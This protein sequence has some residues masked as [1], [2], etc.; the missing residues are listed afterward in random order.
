M[1]FNV[2]R[3]NDEDNEDNHRN[4]SKIDHLVTKIEKLQSSDRKKRVMYCVESARNLLFAGFER[5]TL[6]L[7]FFGEKNQ[8]IFSL[9]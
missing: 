4:L 9:P 3:Q 5:P 1:Y 6:N 2:Y 8:T 7:K